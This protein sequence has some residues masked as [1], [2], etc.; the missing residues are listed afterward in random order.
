M[1]RFMNGHAPKFSTYDLRSLRKIPQIET[2][3][4]EQKFEM[5][6]V[7]QVLPFRTNPYVVEELIDWDDVPNDPNFLLT[8]PQ[9]DMLIP[10]HFDAVAKLL[11]QGGGK[12]GVAGYGQPDPAGFEPTTCRSAPT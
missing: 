1:T 5:E 11:K 4:E 2:L 9:K 6:V 10:E 3:T 12:E 8:F 7:A